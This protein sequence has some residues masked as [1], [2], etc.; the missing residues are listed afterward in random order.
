MAGEVLARVARGLTLEDRYVSSAREDLVIRAHNQRSQLM[1]SGLSH[2]SSQVID[3]SL[4]EQIQRWICQSD[5]AKSIRGFETHLI[6]HLSP[7]IVI[8][9]SD[10]YFR[11]YFDSFYFGTQY[12]SRLR[13]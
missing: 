13:P 7:V 2:S 10:F 1:L 9:E 8:E 5:D 3:Q 12:V 6:H 11:S 4:V